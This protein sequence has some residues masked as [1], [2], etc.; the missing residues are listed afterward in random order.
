MYVKGSIAVAGDQRLQLIEL[1][2]FST[3]GTTFRTANYGTSMAM[4]VRTGVR[5]HA[6]VGSIQQGMAESLLIKTSIH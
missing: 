6:N 3:N 2:L 5:S 1:K 4:L